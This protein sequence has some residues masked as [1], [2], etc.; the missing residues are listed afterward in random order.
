MDKDAFL[1][2]SFTFYSLITK[3]SRVPGFQDSSE[4]LLKLINGQAGCFLKGDND[5]GII[6]AVV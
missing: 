2:L 6:C 4:K 1:F 3:D 5:S